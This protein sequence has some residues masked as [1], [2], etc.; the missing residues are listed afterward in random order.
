M[1]AM[2]ILNFCLDYY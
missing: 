2:F 1:F